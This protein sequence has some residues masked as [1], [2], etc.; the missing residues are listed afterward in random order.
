MR[1][2]TA[3][4]IRQAYYGALLQ[5][6][7]TRAEESRIQAAQEMVRTTRARFEVGKDIEASVHRAEA[8]L[9]EAERERVMRENERAKMIFD[10][11]RARF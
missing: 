7:M 3:L 11:R 9:A 10:G 1:A 2:E 6:E 5:Q 4:R 8:E